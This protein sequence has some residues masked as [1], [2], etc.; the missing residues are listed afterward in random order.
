MEILKQVSQVKEEDESTDLENLGTKLTQ[1]LN[2]KRFLIVLDNVYALNV[3]YNLETIVSKNTN[4]GSRVILITRDAYLARCFGLSVA[5][6]KLDLLKED[7]GWKLFL[8]KAKQDKSSEEDLEK[9]IRKPLWKKCCGLPLA[10]C[11]LAGVVYSKKLNNISEWPQEID[12]IMPAGEEKDD[13]KLQEDVLSSLGKLDPSQIWAL[14]YKDL[15]PHLKACLHYLSLFPKSYEIP[16]RRILQLWVAEGLVKK[17]STDGE[18]TAPEDEVKN[19]FEELEARSMIEVAKRRLDGTA[20]TCRI[21]ITLRDAFCPDAE[22]KSD[23]AS[24]SKNLNIRRLA[25]HFDIKNNPPP[26]K[27]I[28]YLRSFISFKTRKSDKPAKE[29]SE[30]LNKTISKRLGF[31]LLRVL[32]LEGAYKPVLPELGKLPLLTYVGLRWTFLDE[33][34]DSVGELSDLETLDVKHTNI[35]TLPM[36]IWKAKK[37]RHLY[38]NEIHFEFPE[39]ISSGVSLAD[40]VQT[41]WGLLI[42]FKKPPEYWL[43]SLKS[44]KKL[45]LTCHS[46]SIG[47][48]TEWIGRLSD[49]RTLRLRSVNDYSEPSDLKLGSIE[50]L[51]HLTELYLLGKF[52]SGTKEIKLEEIRLPQSLKILTLSVSNLKDDPMPEL[53]K[54]KNLNI[55]RLLA[56]SYTG[57]NMICKE[58]NFPKLRVLKIWVLKELE[59]WTIEKGAMP[60]LSELEIRYCPNLEKTE[61]LEN[62]STLKELKLTNMKEEFASKVKKIISEHI[63]NEQNLETHPPW[64]S[65]YS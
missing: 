30:F 63:I 14:G 12:K 17:S 40:N 4:T 21:P 13:L 39:K 27:D 42:G 6:L 36:S 31:G 49:L 47:D 22:E 15:P 25:E 45:G 26:S 16:V 46:K 51:H 48:I 9:F 50:K 28:E 56:H 38:M 52:L 43:K 54:L 7:D 19:F 64:V 61:G 41:L 29:V 23:S 24:T 58:E 2:G 37:L 3:W 33:I 11:V 60:L 55:L 18:Q 62:L 53:G 35:T 1:K 5:L 44:L 8:K 59:E 34:P 10:I 65:F 32:D 20:K 57:K